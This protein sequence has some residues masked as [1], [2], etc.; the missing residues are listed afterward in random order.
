M[1]NPTPSPFITS[2][3]E[4]KAK[5]L[6]IS[7]MAVSIA[8]IPMSFGLLSIV[9]AI[10]GH[11]AMR[12]LTEVGNTT[13]RGFATAGIIVGWVAFGISIF[14]VLVFIGVLIGIATI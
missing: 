2:E 11:I 3:A 6:A 7:S 13:H 12:K 14:A 5:D 8:A 4:Q 9:G 10:L 1:T